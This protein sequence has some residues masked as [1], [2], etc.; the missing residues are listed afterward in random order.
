MAGG[1]YAV[2]MFALM[3]EDESGLVCS[4]FDA[5]GNLNVVLLCCRLQPEVR[6]FEAE[7]LVSGEV[8]RLLN[9]P[10]EINGRK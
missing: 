1:A 6:A 5:P 3:V 7:L 9:P 8:I 4:S 2:I 10:L